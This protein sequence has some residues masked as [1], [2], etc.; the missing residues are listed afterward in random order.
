VRYGIQY[1]DID[2]AGGAAYT[3]PTYTAFNGQETTT[4]ATIRIYPG[5]RIGLPAS[6]SVWLTL[7][8]RLTPSPVP[9]KTAYFNWFAQ[10][11][12][13]VTAYLNIK[14]G[15][16][17][18][19]QNIKGVTEGSSNITFSNNWAPRLGATYDYL[20]NGESKVFFHYGR[21]FEKIPN[22]LAVRALVAEVQT[23]GYYYDANLTQPVPGTGVVIGGIPTGIEGK[24]TDSPYE[25]VSQYSDEYVAGIEQQVGAGFTLGAR[26][27]YRTIGKVIEDV[28]VDY[29][30]A[31]VPYLEGT[32][33]APGMTAENFLSNTSG[34]FISNVDGHYPGFPAFVR[35]YTALEITGEKRLSDNWQILGSWRIAKL[36]GNYEGLFRRD[37]G[38]SDPNITSLG[39]FADSPYVGFTFAEGNLPNDI[40]N[41]F[42]AFGSYLWKDLATGFGL[43]VCTGFPMTELGSIPFYGDSERLLGPR[44]GLGRS[45]TIATFD[46]HADYP[47]P[48]G[49]EDLRLVVGIDAFNLF[50]SQAAEDL[51]TN[52]EYDNGTLDPDL[53][54]DFLNPNLRTFIAP[55]TVQF[56][57]KFSF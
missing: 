30:S 49:T 1:E 54:I 41:Q 2:Y 27:I 25:T 37:N 7:R 6:T 11:S 16:R 10:D 40:R 35:D 33:T 13:N 48:L 43:N 28:Q 17:W 9:T 5:T 31:P 4:G 12:W 46:V 42:K 51:Y 36:N 32:T 44:G 39:D 23:N 22:D 34:Y 20:R 50:N 24:T 18:E 45:D 55:R 38:Q 19:R 53:D 21:F 47:I 3:G 15:V 14:A 57:A 29:T 26:L 52:A 56:L 8:N